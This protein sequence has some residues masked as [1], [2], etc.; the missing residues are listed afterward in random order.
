M[1]INER[2]EEIATL[3]RQEV[4]LAEMNSQD[5]LSQDLW[6]LQMQLKDVRPC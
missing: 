3:H 6:Y 4:D 5:F 2:R 1:K